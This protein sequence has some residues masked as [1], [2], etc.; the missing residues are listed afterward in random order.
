M[1]SLFTAQVSLYKFEK[2]FMKT[3]K[4]YFYIFIVL[5][6]YT[7]CTSGES[8]NKPTIAVTIE[9][10]RYFT[11][12][13][14]GENYHV[15]SMIPNGNNPETYEPTSRQMVD[16]GKSYLY[17]KVGQ[18]GFEQTWVNKIQQNIPQMSVIDSSIGIEDAQSSNIQKDPHTWMSGRNAHII[19]QNIYQALPCPCS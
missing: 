9:P 8:N 14:A 17:I 1:S 15:I 5:V 16:I 3:L 4:T 18:L 12:Q 19:A 10:L 2:R 6:L 11:E 7:S 13:I